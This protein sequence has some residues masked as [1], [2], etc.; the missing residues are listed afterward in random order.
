MLIQILKKALFVPILILFLVGCTADRQ[1]TQ[2]VDF[3]TASITEESIRGELANASDSG[4]KI[5]LNKISSVKP[6]SILPVPRRLL[7]RSVMRVL[8]LRLLLKT[9]VSA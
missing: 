1:A 7:F 2:T 9:L 5:K 3:A 6:L 4:Y 8:K